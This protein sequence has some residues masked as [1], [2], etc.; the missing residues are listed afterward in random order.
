MRFI[1]DFS[2]KEKAFLPAFSFGLLILIVA[3][4][5]TAGI[6]EAQSFNKFFSLILSE[7]SQHFF[8]FGIFAALLG[9]GFYKLRKSPFPFFKVGLYAIS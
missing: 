4:L 2:I 6:E 5:P 1:Q 8:A 7:Y 9:Y 3:S